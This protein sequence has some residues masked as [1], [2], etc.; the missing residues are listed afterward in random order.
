LKFV[1]GAARVAPPHVA[2]AREVE[3]VQALDELVLRQ[4]VDVLL[5]GEVD[6]PS[7]AYEMNDFF[8]T[9]RILPRHALAQPR[10][11]VRVLEVEEVP[12]VVPDEAVLLDGLA[13]AA[14][15]AVGLE[16]ERTE[17]HRITLWGKRGEALGKF[18]AKGDRIFVEGRLQT[19]SYEKNGEKRYSTEVVATNIILSGGGRG[20]GEG[21][22]AGGGGSARPPREA[23]PE[24]AF[25]DFGDGGA[26]GG[27]GP[28]GGGADDD[29]PF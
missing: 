24:P 2:R 12:G 7:R 21:A 19:S 8:S 13:P 14:D 26:G 15:L 17:W 16:D 27:G 23:A 6:L 20:R 4:L 11:D 1:S 25:D 29:I 5:E 28:A 9:V 22:P 3:V 18:L 10:L